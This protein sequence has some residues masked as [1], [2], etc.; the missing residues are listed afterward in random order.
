MRIQDSKTP[1]VLEDTKFRKFPVNEDFSMGFC[2]I[3][4]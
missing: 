4:S 3:W 2:D 1:L